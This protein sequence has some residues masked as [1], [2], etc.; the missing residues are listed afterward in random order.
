LPKEI[1]KEPTPFFLQPRIKSCQPWGL[2]V[3]EGEE[4]GVTW[5][6]QGSS[7]GDIPLLPVDIFL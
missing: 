5:E 3:G 7:P 2:G 1:L 6:I 4:V